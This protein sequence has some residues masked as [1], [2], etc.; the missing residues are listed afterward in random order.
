ML[1]T[2]TVSLA[3]FRHK[4]I[5]EI[6]KRL[7]QTNIRILSA[8]WKF[9]P[10]NLLE[11]SRRTG[12]PFTSV[13]HRVAKIES[14]SNRVA[15]LIPQHSKLGL[16]R[17]V[18]L[19]HASPGCEERVTEA[20]KLPNL[21]RSVNRCEG[22]F[23]HLSVQHIPVRL[24]KQFRTY[25]KQL[26][27]LGLITEY[28]LIPTGQYIP[29]FPDF[30]FYDPVSNQWTFDWRG[31]FAALKNKPSKTIE[32]PE[33]YA[34]LA[35]KKDLLIVKELEKNARISFTDIAPLL[36]MSLQGV[37]Y[38]YDKRLVPTEIV[39]YFGFDVWPYPEEVSAYH[40]IL[41][42]FTSGQ[43]M[44]SFFTLVHEL[45]FVLGVSKL[46]HEDTLMVRTYMLQSQVSNLFAFLSQMA[47]E[48]FLESYSSVRHDFVARE[49]QTISYELFDDEKGWTFDLENCL[50][51]L[52]KL[53]KPATITQK[54]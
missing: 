13:Y 54:V 6:Q 18:L 15:S 20:L 33:S 42:K 29:N 36:G 38:H 51:E 19:V 23:T 5:R 24:M 30:K 28:K 41:L 4:G 40:E 16:V 26:A 22:T 47:R 44:N 48:G 11:V 45:F 34:I 31:W 37:K 12:I 35:D 9:G 14:K 43:A 25:V 27:E 17:T 2:E 46:L 8:M 1:G 7:D 49:S 3:D 10:R 21:W 39:K 50:S 53:A 32:D 52:S